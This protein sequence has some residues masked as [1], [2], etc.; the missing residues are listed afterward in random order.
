MGSGA[1]S[2]TDPQAQ[3][4]ML[5]TSSKPG[6]Q[7]FNMMGCSWPALSGGSSAKQFPVGDDQSRD[8]TVASAGDPAASGPARQ[9][10][11][12]QQA[13]SEFVDVGTLAHQGQLCE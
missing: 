1:V 9:C 13:V 5:A 4:S 7:A 8:V 3:S 12:L 6:V 10:A 2:S 11:V